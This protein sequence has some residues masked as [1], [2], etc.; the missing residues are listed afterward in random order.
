MGERKLTFDDVA[1][2]YTVK[3]N[4]G[5]DLHLCADNNWRTDED[6]RNVEIDG[7]DKE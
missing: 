6:L 5:L 2:L 4:S 3:T 7:E 1:V